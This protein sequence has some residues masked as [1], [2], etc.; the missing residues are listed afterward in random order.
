VDEYLQTNAVPA[1]CDA[2][3]AAI[4]D[5]YGLRARYVR[6]A[7]AFGALFVLMREQ[8]QAFETAA[9]ARRQ[10]ERPVTAT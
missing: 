9:A 6:N 7:G 2:F 10:I 3:C 4:R 8:A 1:S 5:R